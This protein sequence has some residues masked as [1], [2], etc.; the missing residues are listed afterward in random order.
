[1]ALHVYSMYVCDLNGP[2]KPGDVLGMGLYPEAMVKMSNRTRNT[3][4]YRSIP[5][6]LT[7]MGWRVLV[8]AEFVWFSSA[9]VQLAHIYLLDENEFLNL[10]TSG[11]VNQCSAEWARVY[12]SLRESHIGTRW[13]EDANTENGEVRL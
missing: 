8:A 2:I 4:G 1:M 6:F 11:Y 5:A 3:G 12:Q 10:C 13:A 7:T 9:P